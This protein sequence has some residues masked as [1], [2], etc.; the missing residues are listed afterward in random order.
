L[1]PMNEDFKIKY[2]RISKAIYEDSDI[3]FSNQ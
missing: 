1:K 2:T 3:F